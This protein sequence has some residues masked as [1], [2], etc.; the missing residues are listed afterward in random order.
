MLIKIIIENF[1]DILESNNPA[2]N[3]PASLGQSFS[4][5]MNLME[6]RKMFAHFCPKHP[7]HILIDYY[8][9]NIL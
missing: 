2:K 9:F 3:L 1:A 4:L 6:V 5:P 7:H 8:K